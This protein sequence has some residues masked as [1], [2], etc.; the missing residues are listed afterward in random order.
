MLTDQ[1]HEDL[2]AAMKARDE[3][4]VSVLRLA[5]AAVTEEAVAGT[6]ARDLSDDDVRTV[7]A[8][9]VKRRDEAATAFAAAGRPERAERERAERAVL[10]RYLPA[11][12]T[13]AEVAALVDEALA[14]GGF[15]EPSQMGQAMKAAMARVGGRADGRVVSAIVRARLGA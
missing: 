7:L 2:T 15:D 11:P 9:E 8:R 5:L 14:E 10:A 6:A 1:L 13:E 4:A 3:L 12:L